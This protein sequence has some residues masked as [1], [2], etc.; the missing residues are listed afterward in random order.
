[1]KMR[2]QPMTF[3]RIS[4]ILLDLLEDVL[5]VCLV[6]PEV[7]GNTSSDDDCE[8]F[9]LPTVE[10]NNLAIQLDRVRFRTA[11]FKAD[12]RDF[13]STSLGRWLQTHEMCVSGSR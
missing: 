6:F 2:R 11:T 13:F 12:Q 10:L 9:P 1:M 8:S 4:G 7:G 5:P 3:G